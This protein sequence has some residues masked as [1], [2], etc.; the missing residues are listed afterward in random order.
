M[1]TLHSGQIHIKNFGFVAVLPG[2]IIFHPIPSHLPIC[3]F[4]FKKGN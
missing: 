1:V 2:R 3:D 4:S